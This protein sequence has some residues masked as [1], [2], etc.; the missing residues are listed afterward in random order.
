MWATTQP[1]AWARTRGAALALALACSGCT[2]P[3]AGDDDA[4]AP[5][6]AGHDARAPAPDAARA[7][8]D[9]L[10]AFSIDAAPEDTGPEDA[11]RASFDTGPEPDVPIVPVDA[12]GPGSDA[13]GDAPL[14]FG[15][16]GVP[17]SPGDYV[18]EGTPI[19]YA[20]ISLSYAPSSGGWQDAWRDADGVLRLHAITDDL[21]SI[22]SD[23]ALEDAAFVAD[24]TYVARA[25]DA[26][27]PTTGERLVFFEPPP[28]IPRA[29]FYVALYGADGTRHG[30]LQRVSGPFDQLDAAWTGTGFSILETTGISTTV[31][32]NTLRRI[33]L[34]ASGRIV[35]AVG[36]VAL[37]MFLFAVGPTS[38]VDGDWLTFGGYLVGSIMIW[39][40]ADGTISSRDIF[41]GVRDVL[42]AT[43]DAAT[44]QLWL[45]MGFCCLPV[46][47]IQ[48]AVLDGRSGD[49]IADFAYGEHVWPF[50]MAVEDASTV[51]IVA[52]HTDATG[53]SVRLS[54]DR[55]RITGASGAVLQSLLLPEGDDGNTSRLRY[56][57][58]R[59]AIAWGRFV[60]EA[61]LCP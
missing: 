48:I 25:T 58:G 23:V 60:D 9:R 57:G 29:A 27:S 19:P 61:V 55:V 2:A 36:P 26:V 33:E 20:P 5:I 18:L 51:G 38:Y 49:V 17:C 43:Y 42:S 3:E 47:T 24:T 46:S 6:D 13:A 53:G 35:A 44:H 16:A 56:L 10:D 41:G 32:T 15:D 12:P 37:D 4:A 14:T 31:G 21:E 11:Y 34:D 8:A 1:M 39:I 54:L 30:P 7:D 50:A 28:S 52:R 45:V 59:Y 22:T 40:H